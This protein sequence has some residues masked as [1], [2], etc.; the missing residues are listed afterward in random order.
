V[1]TPLLHRKP[2]ERSEPAVETAGPRS[3]PGRLLE[4]AR[5]RPDT[6]ACFAKRRG[7][8]VELTWAD[9]SHEVESL[10]FG[11]RELGVERGDRVALMSGPRSELLALELAV[12]SLG[13]ISMGLHP[14]AAPAELR[15]QLEAA[16]PVLLVAEDQSCLST[17]GS[18]SSE[19]PFSVA[20]LILDTRDLFLADTSEQDTLADL[21]SRGE[22]FARAFS[23]GLA[24][25]VTELD[26]DDPVTLMSTSGVDAPARLAVHSHRTLLQGAQVTAQALSSRRGEHRIIAQLPTSDPLGKLVAVMLPLLG[27][28][29]VYFPERASAVGQA[30]F[31]VAPTYLHDRPR[32]YQ[33]T[34]QQVAVAI[35]RSSPVSRAA[36]RAACR[37]GGRV[38]TRRWAGKRPSPPL[39]AL[40]A[41]ARACVFVPLLRRLGYHRVRL[42]HIGWSPVAPEVL[43]MWQVWGIDTRVVYGLAEH[44]GIVAAQTRPFAGPDDALAVVSGSDITL[45]LTPD[46]ELRLRPPA[47]FLGYWRGAERAEP[48]S[49]SIA[50]CDYASVE[51][52]RL[53]LIG[54]R[55][56]RRQS[57][58]GLQMNLERIECAVKA[59]A[60]VR[61]AVAD[62][63]DAGAVTVFVELSSDVVASWAQSRQIVYASYA[64]LAR[65]PEIE[66]LAR[67]EVVRANIVLGEAEQVREVRV[68]PFELYL[69][70]DFV[71]TTGKVRRRA[72][73]S[74][75]NPAESGK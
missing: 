75:M 26:G 74:A 71:T 46:G 40:Y 50:T 48:A 62:V 29:R 37:I 8:Y 33:H 57:A 56:S 27:V 6:P 69:G 2:S 52:G 4:R 10:A 60:F 68:L 72:V 16:A 1:S 58:A 73:Y 44:A 36:Y 47:P 11:L 12:W 39:A 34:V 35:R 63:D 17:I 19:L 67:A 13:A 51:D 5:D 23:T 20:T 61:E 49:G 38:I 41:L 54:S 24:D 21:R 32:A 42:A 65:R 15:E 3:I 43:R 22:A 45:E 59:S 25:L 7:R 9:L 30:I 66:H 53:R 18:L 70:S 28:A 31:E 14:L 64:D 55:G